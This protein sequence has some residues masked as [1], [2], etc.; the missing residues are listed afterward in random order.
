[1]V[2]DVLGF[3]QAVCL[4]V[5]MVVNYCCLLTGGLVQ[6]HALQQQRQ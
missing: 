6:A 3:Y 1:M 5:G 4:R 2:L